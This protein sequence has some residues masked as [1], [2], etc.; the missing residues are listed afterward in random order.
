MRIT[1][2]TPSPAPSSGV[3]LAMQ[4]GADPSAALTL[5]IPI[6]TIVLA[7]DTALGQPI[8]LLLIHRIDKNVEDG[9]TR[10]INT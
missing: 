4:A 7:L 1:R 2:P 10:S 3:S 6:A 9:D 8:M 5:G